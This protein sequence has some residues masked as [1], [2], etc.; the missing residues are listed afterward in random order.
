MKFIGID[1]AK[2]TYDV[3]VLTDGQYKNRQFDNHQTGFNAF[4]KWAN[5]TTTETII[6]FEAT[7]IYALNLAKFLHANPC[8]VLVINPIKTHAFAKMEMARNKTDQADAQSIARYCQYL[9]H[10]GD[11]DR[12]LFIPKPK[13]FER[14]QFLNTRLEQLNKIKTQ[15]I[16]HLESSMDKMITRSTKQMCKLIEQQ[17]H[18]IKSEIARM[19]A[20]NQQLNVQ[21][22]LLTSINGI[23][24]KTAWAILAYLGDTNLFAN[25]RQVSSYAGLN[26]RIEQSGSSINQSRLSKMGHSRLRRSLYMPALCAVK[27]NPLMCDL[28]Q[29]LIAKG[30]PK[31]VALAAVMRKLLVLAYGV[32]KSQK[33]FDPNYVS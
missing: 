7:G 16:N 33:A 2:A 32:L 24:D 4:L 1:I 12:Y 21:V 9:W 10:K 14:L 5:L 18:Q 22:K 15:E 29:R 26:P 17:I 19:V 3:A 25:A 8:H 27:H 6:C 20:N 13:D 23:A 11:I 31:K 30:K 28:Y